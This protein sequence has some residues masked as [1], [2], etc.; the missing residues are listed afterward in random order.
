MNTCKQC[1]AVTTNPKFCCHSCNAKY[2]NNL[3]PKI[4]GRKTCQ[5]CKIPISYKQTY[6]SE[7][8]A[9]GCRKT[10][11][12]I[13]TQD[14]TIRDVIY[15]NHHKSSAFALVRTRARGE[16]RKHGMNAC[17]ICGYNKHIEISH[18]KAISDFDLD[19]QVSVVN[20]KENIWPLCPNHHW[21]FDN[22]LLEVPQ[23]GL[24]PTLNPF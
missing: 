4:T 15:L 16:G 13:I 24:E 12:G 10:V 21:E 6:C 20:S 7:C 14:A 5:A 17:A 23:V 2:H 9:R 18:K 19:T 22:G 8:K 3:K 1:C 11:N